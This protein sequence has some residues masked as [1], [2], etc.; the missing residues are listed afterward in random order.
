[1]TDCPFVAEANAHAVA[2]AGFVALDQVRTVDGG[3]LGKKP[4]KLAPATI[5]EVHRVLQE[6]FA[7]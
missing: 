4:G 5:R 1:M 6:Q 2:C 3:R 7:E